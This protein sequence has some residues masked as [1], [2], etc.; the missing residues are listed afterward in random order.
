MMCISLLEITVSRAR[1]TLVHPYP[2]NGW[3][4]ARLQDIPMCHLG[5]KVLLYGIEVVIEGF[6]HL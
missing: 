4:V 3:K 2:P 6:E 1:A 5:K